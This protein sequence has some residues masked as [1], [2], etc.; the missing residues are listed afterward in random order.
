MSSLFDVR[1]VEGL[2]IL[3]GNLLNSV[4]QRRAPTSCSIVIIS[5]SFEV[6]P[7]SEQLLFK[8]TNSA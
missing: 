6:G 7:R 5:Y 3:D 2:P 1:V 4:R 8:V